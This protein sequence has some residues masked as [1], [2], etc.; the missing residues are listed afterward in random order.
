[1]SVRTISDEAELRSGPVE[2]DAQITNL[3]GIGLAIMVADCTPVMLADPEDG[4]IAAVH[5]GRQGMAARV[6]PTTLA[7][8]REAVADPIHAVSRPSVCASCHEVSAAL[9]A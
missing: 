9:L 7:A 6:V 2:A 4:L 3:T 8:M 1:T 5:A